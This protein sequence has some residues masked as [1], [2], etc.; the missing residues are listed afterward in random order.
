ME[1]R[2]KDLSDLTLW[3]MTNPSIKFLNLG[4]AL[5]SKDLFFESDLSIASA[6]I[7]GKRFSKLNNEFAMPFFYEQIGQQLTTQVKQ[8]VPS[9]DP[10]IA[11]TFKK[12]VPG[13]FSSCR[14]SAF[15][16]ILQPMEKA[17]VCIRNFKDTAVMTV[18]IAISR[19][20]LKF[21]SM[22]TAFS[23]DNARKIGKMKRIVNFRFI[24][25]AMLMVNVV[26]LHI[27]PTVTSS[28]TSVHLKCI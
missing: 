11:I 4:D 19:L 7:Q 17:N 14:A 2:A 12:L 6:K 10:F 9:N 13:F 18:F 27:P 16:C 15:K 23:I 5:F 28:L 1:T 22:K 20:V 8:S 25:N 24:K 26:E 21:T 3:Y